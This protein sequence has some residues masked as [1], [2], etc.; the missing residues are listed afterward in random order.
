MK[1]I[2]LPKIRVE[3]WKGKLRYE[4][5]PDES[6]SIQ[7][8]GITVWNGRRSHEPILDIL[9]KLKQTK[10]IYIVGHDIP[11][12]ISKHLFALLEAKRLEEAKKRGV[13]PEQFEYE[14]ILG[15]FLGLL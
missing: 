10:Q 5:S 6:D 9:A 14:D 4:L 8:E 11:L 12:S 13:P 7:V 15:V 2:K 1:V 3:N